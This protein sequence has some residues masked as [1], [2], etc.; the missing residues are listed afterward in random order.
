MI[1]RPIG[2][3]EITPIGDPVVANEQQQVADPLQRDLNNYL[4]TRDENAPEGAGYARLSRMSVDNL[5]ESS[6]FT[7][8]MQQDRIQR[9]T[10]DMQEKLQDTFTYPDRKSVV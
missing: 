5:I 2:E 10:A 4:L 6:L 3:E 9:R 8:E 1:Q 7:E